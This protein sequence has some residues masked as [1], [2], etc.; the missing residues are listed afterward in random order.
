MRMDSDIWVEEGEAAGRPMWFPVKPDG[1][2]H[3]SVA[4]QR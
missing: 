3:E 2:V 4:T 1:R